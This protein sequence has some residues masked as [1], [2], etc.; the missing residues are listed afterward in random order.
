M[1]SGSDRRRSPRVGK[2][3]LIQANS[4]LIGSS[5]NLSRH[6]ALIELHEPLRTELPVRLDLAIQDQ[7]MELQA[8]VV[9]VHQVDQGRYNIGLEFQDLSEEELKALDDFMLQP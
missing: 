4:F 8:R 6:G 2:V 5:L 3:S 7:V 1:E 9:H